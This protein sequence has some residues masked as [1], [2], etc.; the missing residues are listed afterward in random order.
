MATKNVAK[1]HP[2]LLPLPPT[3][4]VK[5]V[6]ASPWMLRIGVDVGASRCRERLRAFERGRAGE[7]GGEGEVLRSAPCA[8]D[9]S[10]T[11]S[12]KVDCAAIRVT[13]RTLYTLPRPLVRERLERGR[14]SGNDVMRTQRRRD[15]EEF[16]RAVI[17]MRVL[18][19]KFYVLDAPR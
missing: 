6:R 2:F 14:T 16:H 19:L 18:V 1:G 12:R 11:P 3:Q 15:A 5:K 17:L 13:L 8:A 9:I 7:G 4:P 10:N